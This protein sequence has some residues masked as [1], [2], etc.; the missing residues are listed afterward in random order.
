[1]PKRGNAWDEEETLYLL[2]AID[3]FLPINPEEWEQV[4]ALHDQRYASMR[5][6]VK[7]LMR[8]FGELAR[9]TEP[10]GSPR[11]PPT[12]KLAKEV[13]ERIRAK[14]DGTTGS[15]EDDELLFD[16]VDED[17]GEE[18][19][20]NLNNSVEEPMDGALEDYFNADAG[21]QQGDLVIP[22]VVMAS[23]VRGRSLPAVGAGSVASSA[24]SAAATAAAS[25]TN[26]CSATVCHT[27]HWTQLQ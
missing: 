1:M 25:A 23:A 2:S 11:M 10:T 18:G 15:P 21:A 12:V 27:S 22:R 14:T 4:K 13:R 26:Q 16:E 9:T 20:L 8:V 19:E 3:E 24:P 6:T 17:D 5:R 7:T